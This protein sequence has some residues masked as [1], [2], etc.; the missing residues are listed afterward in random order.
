MPKLKKVGALLDTIIAETESDL[1]KEVVDVARDVAQFLKDGSPQKKR[2]T[3]YNK[4]CST[5]ERNHLN[6]GMEHA[7]DA[8][9]HFAIFD[10]FTSREDGYFNA[11]LSEKLNQL[12]KAKEMT[13]FNK[14]ISKHRLRW[15]KLLK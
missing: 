3:L 15:S 8:L 1:K 9:F 7:P 13:R 4:L 2:E 11:V 10:I 5:A 14:K 6:R 12:A